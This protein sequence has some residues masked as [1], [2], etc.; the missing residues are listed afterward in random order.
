MKN[1]LKL[2]VGYLS[3]KATKKIVPMSLQYKKFEKDQSPNAMKKQLMKNRF[4]KENPHLVVFARKLNSNGAKALKEEQESQA[5]M[6]DLIDG[7]AK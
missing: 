3:F 7:T 1:K 5:S 2:S 6:T 4:F